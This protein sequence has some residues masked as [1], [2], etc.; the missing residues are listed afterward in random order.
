MGSPGHHHSLELAWFLERHEVLKS[1]YPQGN[2]GV[3]ARNRKEVSQGLW[4]IFVNRDGHVCSF[5]RLY[6]LEHQG[7]LDSS[8]VRWTR[9]QALPEVASRNQETD[10]G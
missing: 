10:Y 7:A 2:G 3:P 8:A 5:I 4:P 1:R 9:I 6:T